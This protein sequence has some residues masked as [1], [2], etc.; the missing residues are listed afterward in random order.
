[1]LQSLAWMGWST[2]EMGKKIG[3]HD[4]P[5]NKIRAGKQ[6]RIHVKTAA[7]IQW[8]YYRH[9]MIQPEGRYADTVR[10]LA[11]GKGWVSPLAWDN[12]KTDSSPKALTPSNH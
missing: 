4:V 11:R 2:S 6:A 9:C 8:F 7:K 3:L 10:A 1:M 5:L 12:I